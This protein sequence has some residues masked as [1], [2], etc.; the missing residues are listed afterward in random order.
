MSEAE[1]RRTL[2]AVHAA[3]SP[4][5]RFVAYQVRDAVA[6]RARPIFGEPDSESELLNLPPM[7]VYTWRV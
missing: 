6:E 7:R 4:G 5:G 2:E 3:L 1:A